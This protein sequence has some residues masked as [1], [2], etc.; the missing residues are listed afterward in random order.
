MF[1]IFPEPIMNLPEAEIHLEGVKIY[2]LQGENAQIVFMAFEKDTEIPEHSH[3]SQWEIVL[4]GKVDYFE[5]NVKHTYKKGDRFFISKGTKHS[6]KVYAG[7]ASI[8]FFNQKERYK[9]K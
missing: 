5:N 3:E 7:Y 4:E 6:A 8:A 2:L 9:K 1:D